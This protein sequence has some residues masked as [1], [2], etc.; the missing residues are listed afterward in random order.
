MLLGNVPV[1]VV[2]R[3]AAG[4]VDGVYQTGAETV[5]AYDAS[6]GFGVQPLN[7]ADYRLLPERILKAVKLKV[8]VPSSISLQ[9][10]SLDAPSA[11]SDLIE[12]DGQRYYL[13]ALKSYRTSGLFQHQRLY[14]VEPEGVRGDA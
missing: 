9:T 13:Y 2:R 8:Y 4:V 6:A 7:D 5:T 11:A 1:S 14:L 3:S 12:Y 10:I